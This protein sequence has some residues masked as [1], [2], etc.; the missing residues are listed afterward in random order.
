MARRSPNPD[1]SQRR[2]CPPAADSSA[3]LKTHAAPRPRP[4]TELP[5]L[6][7][8]N[9]GLLAGVCS[10]IIG[11]MTWDARPGLLEARAAQPADT[12]YNLLVRGFHAGQLN[13]KSEVPPGLAALADPYDPAA[14]S[15]Y[16]LADRYP[17]HDLS[18][19]NGKL[20]LYFGVTPALLL[21]W[22]YA[23]ATG[24]YLSHTEAAV[25]LC[26]LGFLAAVGVLLSVWR[27]CFAEV[28]FFVLIA[29]ILAVGLST[30]LPV[31][32][33]RCDVYEVSICCGHS[34]VMLTLLGIWK[35]LDGPPR[36]FWWL[37]GASLAFG[38][39]IGA[40]PSLLFGAVAL[41][42]PVAQAGR[43][44]PQ[45]AS[46]WHPLTLLIPALL[47]VTLIGLGLLLYN[48]MRFGDPL[49]FGQRFLLAAHREDT[50]QH[51]GLSYLWFNF[52]VYFLEPARW[53]LRLPFV[54]DIP[55]PPLPLGHG[56]IE[57]PFGV[58][59]N[60]PFVWLGLLAPLSWRSRPAENRAAMSWFVGAVILFL[61]ASTVT[62]LLYYTACL[63]YQADFV[64]ALAL[65]A[66]LG[67]FGLEQAVAG[68]PAWR[69][70]IRCGWGFLLAFSLLFT[71]C[72][73]LDRHAEA[74]TLAASLLQER[75]HASEALFELR[76]A[77]KIRPDDP[78]T[79]SELGIALFQAGEVEES[80]SHFRRAVALEPDSA[81]AR[82]NLGNAYL[83]TSRLEEAV[84][85]FQ[86]A[87]QIAPSDAEAQHNWALALLHGGLSDEAMRHFEQAVRIEPG[88]ADDH[89]MLGDLLAQKGLSREAAS[90]YEAAL[91]LKPANLQVLNNFAWLLATSPEA[92]IRDGARAYNWPPK[93]GVFPTAEIPPCSKPS[94]RRARSLESL[95]RPLLPPEVLWVWPP[96]RPTPL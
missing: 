77:A 90:H 29:A 68:R 63:R 64:P 49:E 38:F 53:N 95:L 73:S 25:I 71:C 12:Y 32:L 1:F 94:P 46:G 85:E 60:L 13:L 34:L 92:S 37:A 79:Q 89:L 15:E 48:K 74:H 28:S 21:F 26:A 76:A 40:R 57:H 93:L 88:L 58:L 87:A 39:A 91:K 55:C 65:L 84:L 33:A 14:N 96:R 45:S 42:V 36:R 69:W 62:I 78:P 19:Y 3:G 24:H 17:V 82:N 86:K 75:G 51:F 47:P 10:L 81:E 2:G 70:P 11:I 5:G 61:G 56:G 6:S 44:K 16:R 4:A 66:V 27:R 67:L 41:L 50:P 54:H 23:I 9:Y 31:I 43:E 20:Y 72:A 59:L 7:W 35:A 8:K 30:L 22:P 18:Y 83:Q 80:L 52:R